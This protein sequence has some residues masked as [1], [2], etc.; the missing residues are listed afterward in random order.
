MTLGDFATQ[1]KSPAQTTTT[2]TVY[3]PKVTLN[4]PAVSAA[5][6]L[7][8]GSFHYQNPPGINEDL[9]ARIVEDAGPVIFE[10]GRLQEVDSF[11]VHMAYYWSVRRTLAAG[12]HTY[13][14]EFRRQGGAVAAVGIE[15]V[16]LHFF[17][18]DAS[19]QET[20]SDAIVNTN[21]TAYV[22]KSGIAA[23]ALPAGTYR[24]GFACEYR[25]P[26]AGA[27]LGLRWRERRDPAGANVITNL[28]GD[29]AGG[30]TELFVN[31]GGYGLA[32]DD[33]W[34]C[35]SWITACRELT[36]D[37]YTYELHFRTSN[38][39]NNVEIQKARFF[40]WQTP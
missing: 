33:P 34:Q 18:L 2:G 20:I 39:A 7:V 31:N 28:L 15:E 37:T 17:Q 8:M 38:A 35:A 26:N 32:A 5:D 30:G 1:V 16:Y 14:V 10:T 12:A 29:N 3:V 23:G 24:M 40:L 36:A 13:G 4:T 25:C 27:K 21:S 11:F 19:Y 6:Y 9:Q 22:L